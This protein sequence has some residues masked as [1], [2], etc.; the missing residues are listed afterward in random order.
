[1]AICPNLLDITA[2]GVMSV[3]DGAVP[4]AGAFM[5]EIHVEAVQMD[6]MSR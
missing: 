2:L 1:M 6:G 4:S 3:D 5:Q